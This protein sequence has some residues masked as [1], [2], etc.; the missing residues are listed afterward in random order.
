MPIKFNTFHVNKIR[1]FSCQ[2][3]LILFI[4]DF[5]I[6]SVTGVN[7]KDYYHIDNFKEEEF[8]SRLQSILQRGIDSVA[9]VLMHSYA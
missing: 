2:L 1:Y 7:G 3:N 9:V 6:K 5:Q 8:K 4:S